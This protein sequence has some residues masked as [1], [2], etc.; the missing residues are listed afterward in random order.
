MGDTKEILRARIAHLR[1]SLSRAEV[2]HGSPLIQDRAIE[3]PPY[4]QSHAVALYSPVGNEVATG[5]ICE[6]ARKA[7]KKI[8]YPGLGA[9][10]NLHLIR[11]LDGEELKPGRYGILEPPEDRILTADDKESL[12]VFVPGLAF[13]LHGN[14]L[15]RGSGWYDQVLAALGEEVS[16]VA[17]AFEFQIVDFVPADSWDCKVHHIITERRLIDCRDFPSDSGWVS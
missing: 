6:H 15:G 10:M 13:D 9:A 17:L 14:R 12:V 16:I 8:F 4:R 2:D 7:G 5:K 11:L 1:D 3:F